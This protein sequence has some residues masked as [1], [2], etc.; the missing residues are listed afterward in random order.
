MLFGS[1]CS[2]ACRPT[3]NHTGDYHGHNVRPHHWVVG[4]FRRKAWQ[5]SRSR[6]SYLWSTH[7]VRKA[8]ILIRLINMY[9]HSD[10]A[11]YL[12]STPNNPWERHAQAVFIFAPFFEGLF[13]GWSTLQAATSAYISDCTSDGSRAHIFSRMTGV[14]FLGLA[15]GPTIGAFLMHHPLFSE[16]IPGKSSMTPVFEVAVLFSFINLVL[17]FVYPESLNSKRTIEKTVDSDK[18]SESFFIS[19]VSP[20]AIF[21]PKVKVLP[22]GRQRKDWSFTLLACGMFLAL[23]SMVKSLSPASAPHLLT[24][25]RVS[26]KSNI[27]TLNTST[28]GALSESVTSQ[29]TVLFC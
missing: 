24:S 28:V 8:L 1:C 19:L 7:H 23:F 12:L 22:S 26:T 10:F 25:N 6:R 13:G 29:L 16:A 18:H 14:F 2:G 17:L 21:L 3:A 5:D 27:Y 20:L 11:F 15:V 4:S 9:L